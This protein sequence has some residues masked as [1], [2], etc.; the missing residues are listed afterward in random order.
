MKSFCFEKEK[1]FVQEA[2]HTANVIM[3]P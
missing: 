2:I 3:Q 1:F